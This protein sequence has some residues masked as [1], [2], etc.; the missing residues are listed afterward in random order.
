M[1]EQ[2]SNRCIVLLP[3]G[4][5]RFTRLFDE[6]FTTAI[7][8]AGLV[9]HPIQQNPED[10]PHVDRLIHEI[11]KADFVFADL[12]QGGNEI[13]LALG[14]ALALAKPLCLIS[15]T[16]E[17]NLPLNLEDLEIIAY[18]AAPFPRDY[19]E[20]R[21]SIT[22]QLVTRQP[23]RIAP[24]LQ[25][26]EP[27]ESSQQTLQSPPK[28]SQK[29]LQPAPEPIRSFQEPAQKPTPTQEPLQSFREPAQKPQPVQEPIQSFWEPE[30]KPQPVPEPIQSFREPLQKPTP[31]EEP[32]RSLR[33]ERLELVQEPIELLQAVQ[34]PPAPRV[35]NIPTPIPAVAA[36]PV[37]Q[38]AP[39]TE[40]F[41]NAPLP[42]ELTSH[43]VLALSIIDIHASSDGLSPRDLGLEMQAKD[44][45]HLTSHA[46][47]S[48]K[49]RKF[50][51]RRPV[52]VTDGA[53]S[54]LSDNLFITWS[55]KNWLLKHG[56]RN[57][58]WQSTSATNEFFMAAP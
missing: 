28:P 19:S 23:Q 8:E 3:A 15:S 4:N 30:Q 58:S 39:A 29:S 26:H 45:A 24:R 10:H 20:L 35:T 16:L 47:S 9:P 55:G 43:E 1:T 17:F 27:H 25:Q 31:V 52:S 5:S 37:P 21:R 12:S 18:P 53:D 42:D 46:M 40:V 54:Y 41:A 50:I 33:G 2:S 34:P 56:K 13:W 51:D 44:S 32:I 7:T 6:L 22:H 11:A 14:C 38:I 48:L 49:R 36:T 57:R